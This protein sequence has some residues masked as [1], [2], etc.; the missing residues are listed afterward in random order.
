V[1]LTIAEIDCKE[2]LNDLS[3]AHDLS[4]VS[5]ME[6]AVS[7]LLFSKGIHVDVDHL[8][9]NFI[10]IFNYIR[11]T[12]KEN[13][14]S[15]EVGTCLEQLRGLRLS[16]RI[17][18]GLEIATSPGQRKSGIYLFYCQQSEFHQKFLKGRRLSGARL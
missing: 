1:Y 13:K 6:L 8:D 4:V 2:H 10:D 9:P 15:A 5:T 16:H 17:S 11:R 18:N 7:A 14:I 3:K 12:S